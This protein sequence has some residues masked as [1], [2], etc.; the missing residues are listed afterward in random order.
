[1]EECFTNA[2]R[3]F[4]RFQVLPERDLTACAAPVSVE[5][6]SRE[7][8]AG[9]RMRNRWKNVLQTDRSFGRFQVLPGR[10]LTA[11]AAPVSVENKKQTP[12]NQ[13]SPLRLAGINQRFRKN[14]TSS[15]PPIVLSDGH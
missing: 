10:D 3:S 2:D 7:I 11:C 14:F 8:W 9:N 1:M 15:P 6:K 4:G 5:N 13:N 12:V